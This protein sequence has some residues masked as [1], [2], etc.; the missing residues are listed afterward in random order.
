M[1]MLKI[2]KF[3]TQAMPYHIEKLMPLSKSFHLIIMLAS[4]LMH[5]LSPPSLSLSRTVIKAVTL[6]YNK[7]LLL[8]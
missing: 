2:L 8:Q 6:L 7:T 1:E 4:V 3:Q 5:L